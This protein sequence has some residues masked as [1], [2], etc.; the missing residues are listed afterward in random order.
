MIRM[1]KPFVVHLPQRTCVATRTK[2]HQD[3][4]LRVVLLPNKKDVCVDLAQRLPGR[5]AYVLKNVAAIKQLQAKNGLSRALKV[6]VNPDIYAALLAA[7]TS[8]P[9]NRVIPH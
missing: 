7:C 5:G 4:L 8:T 2:H 6:A 1:N 9:D 3:A